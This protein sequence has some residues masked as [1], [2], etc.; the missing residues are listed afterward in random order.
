MQHIQEQAKRVC[1]QI[2]KPRKEKM[3]TMESKQTCGLPNTL[4]H[5][6][7]NCAYCLKTEKIRYRVV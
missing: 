2:Y 5:Q 4:L 6:K 3:H 7:T 1:Q